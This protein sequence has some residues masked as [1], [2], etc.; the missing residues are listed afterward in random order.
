[1][2]VLIIFLSFV[3]VLVTAEPYFCSL[4]PSY[5]NCKENYTMWAYSERDNACFIHIY[6]G[7]GGNHNRFMDEELC[8]DTCIN[9]YNLD[10]E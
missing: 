3:L 8:I 5:G 10:V 9:P 6:S 2:K 4:T 1:M 7:C